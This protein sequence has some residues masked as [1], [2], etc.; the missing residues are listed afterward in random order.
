MIIPDFSFE[1]SLLPPGTRYLLGI[2]EVG[3]GPLAGPVTIGAFLLD[4]QTFSP[5]E[6][7]RIKVRDSKKLSESQRQNIQKYFK[8][9]NYS[10]A[11]FSTTSQD[12]DTHGISVC[13]YRL[14]SKALKFY[15]S[16]YDFCL[17]DGNFNKVPL[18]KEGFREIESI[19]QGDAKCFSIAAASIVAKVDRDSQMKKYDIDYPQY[20]FCSHKGYGTKLHLNAIKTHG[21]CPIHR[22]SFKPL[23]YKFPH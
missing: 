8:Q 22:L 14:I 20:G 15:S 7:N 2:D 6:F 23:S 11:T 19:I 18:V 16:Q 13:I 17:I 3:R 21:P 9:N 1:Q 4:L 5:D 10:Y 12:I